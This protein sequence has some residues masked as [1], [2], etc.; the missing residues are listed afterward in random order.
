MKKIYLSALLVCGSL[1][2][3]A[4]WKPATNNIITPWGENLDP[5]HVLP[6]YPRPIMERENWLNLNGLW[7]YTLSTKEE[8]PCHFRWENTGS[9]RYRV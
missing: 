5:Q 3:S 1:I 8:N 9:F 6:E 2:A 7:D 4:Q